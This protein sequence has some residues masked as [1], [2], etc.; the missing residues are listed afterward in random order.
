MARLGVTYSDVTKAAVAIRA[1]GEEPTVD[2]VRGYLGTG[3]RSTIAPLLK[4]WRHERGASDELELPPDLVEAM[5]ALSARVKNAADVQMEQ[6][7]AEFEA[8]A[9]AL[10]EQL[11]G[12]MASN[13]ALQAANEAL[14]AQVEAGNEQTGTLNRELEQLKI[15]LARVEVSRD[16]AASETERLKTLVSEQKNEL[17][18][19]R[20]QSEHFQQ[21]V[22]D[23]RRQERA[24]QL[25]Q[26]QQY[27]GQIKTL[28]DQVAT[29]E[30]RY[31]ALNKTCEDLR[32][33]LS[34]QSHA[35]LTLSDRY[36][37]L[38]GDMESTLLSTKE[39][40]HEKDKLQTR[41]DAATRQAAQAAAALASSMD[42]SKQLAASLEKAEHRLTQAEEATKQQT[43]ANKELTRHM[44]EKEE[45][46]MRL[47][48]A[49]TAADKLQSSGPFTDS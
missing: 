12:E 4:K 46:L 44:T 43:H 21:A 18:A 11:S 33:E 9:T 17:Q 23:D 25:M 5:K 3:S 38:K 45:E 34:E 13:A 32:V 19:V 8:S 7:R 6:L 48:K 28:L 39:V 16:E 37:R 30:S 1:D 14:E 42:T 47:R 24:E 36:N 40:I 15:Q 10:Q 26:I 2:R 49:L 22:A 35:H 29:V 31:T 41:L 20:K 27:Q